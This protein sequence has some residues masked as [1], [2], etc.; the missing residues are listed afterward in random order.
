MHTKRFNTL[1]K[2]W[3]HIRVGATQRLPVKTA[4][5]NFQGQVTPKIGA[6]N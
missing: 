4:L 5:Y 3:V 1:F 6:I 2:K